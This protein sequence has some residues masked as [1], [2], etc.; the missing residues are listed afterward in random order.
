MY[1]NAECFSII[2]AF[3]L[4]DPLCNKSGLVSFYRAIRLGFDLEHP[5]ASDV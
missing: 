3:Y 5:L 2:K 1:H 4:I